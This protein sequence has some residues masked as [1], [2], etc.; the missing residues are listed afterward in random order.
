MTGETRPAAEGAPA[1][2]RILDIG[3][4]DA[5]APANAIPNI[6]AHLVETET[7]RNAATVIMGVLLIGLGYWAYNGVRNSIAETRISS[8]EALLGTVAKGLDVWVGEHT[9]E[10]ARLAKDPV[11]VE[12]A[13]RLAAEA[14]RQS[15]TP[16]RCTAEAEELGSKVQSSL[17]TQGVVA[18]RIVD[19]TGLVLASKD[20]ALCGQRLRSGAFRQ[21]LD[22]ALDGAPQFVR[23][24]P[25]GRAFGQGRVGSTPPG[26]V[27]SGA[28]SHGT[29]PPVAALAMG[30]E[31]DGELATIFSAA[32]PGN[33]AEAYAFSDDG[34]MLTPSRFA[35]ELVAAGVLNETAAGELRVPGPG[36]RSGRRTGGGTR[37][38]AR[39]GCATAHAAGRIGGCGT[40]QDLR[41]RS[42]RRRCHAVSQLSRQRGHRRVALAS[43]LRCGRDRAKYRC[44]RRWRRC[45]SSGSASP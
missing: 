40:R 33:T 17:S 22:L 15:A 32:R 35:E 3:A 4:G 45:A 21:R 34:L 2:A 8:L 30:V 5:E 12:R 13:T 16:G 29:G 42:A 9:A 37:T 14:Q 43:C 10:A 24:Y 39:A 44:S 1:K 20:P 38:G 11:V 41:V 7:W 36:A 25:G 27:V 28:D 6:I 31:A 26:R 23:P 18:F 19:R